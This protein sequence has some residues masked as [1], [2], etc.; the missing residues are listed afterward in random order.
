MKA[1]IEFEPQD[2][3]V[4][5]RMELA[6]IS[7]NP[8]TLDELSKDEYWGVRKNVA[9]NF[10]TTSE[11]LARLARDVNWE[12]RYE[13]AR[14][15]HTSPETLKELSNDK[16][17]EVQIKVAKNTKTPVENL[18]K[19]SYVPELEIHILQNPMTP[20]NVRKEIQEKKYLH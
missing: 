5:F 20:E 1:L 13:V 6:K 7:R 11:T 2:V 10:R 3:S 16:E 19:L 17:R 15:V 8:K 4:S 18:E 12:V 9:R 14:N